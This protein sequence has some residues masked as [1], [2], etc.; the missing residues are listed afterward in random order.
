MDLLEAA[1]A[2][3]GCWELGGSTFRG[4]GIEVVPISESWF[5]MKI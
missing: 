4:T 3:V 2:F 1:P 5:S